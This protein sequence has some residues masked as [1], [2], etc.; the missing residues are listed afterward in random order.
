MKKFPV[1]FVLNWVVMFFVFMFLLSGGGGADAVDK[2]I[3]KP[4]VRNKAECGL[5]MYE[6]QVDP[7]DFSNTTMYEEVG[8]D[9]MGMIAIVVIKNIQEL[10][11]PEYVVLFIDPMGSIVGYGYKIDGMYEIYE[12]V[13]EDENG[14]G[15]YRAWKIT[16]DIEP[17]INEALDIADKIIQ[18]SLGPKPGEI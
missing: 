11:I 8:I 5:F 15:L 17:T 3:E 7:C 18:N 4:A 9:F 13:L 2:K 14:P 1:F 6:S 16:P 10:K 12:F